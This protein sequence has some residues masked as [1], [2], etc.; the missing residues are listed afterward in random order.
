[1]KTFAVLDQVL[2]HP[3]IAVPTTLLP[4]LQRDADDPARFLPHGPREVHREESP[5]RDELRPAAERHPKRRARSAKDKVHEDDREAR[6]AHALG[7]RIVFRHRRL[8]KDAPALH[9]ERREG[10]SRKRGP[11]S[12]EGHEAGYLLADRDVLHVRLR[13]L[14]G[15]S[16]VNDAGKAGR[17]RQ[18]G[19]LNRVDTRNQIIE[20]Q[21]RVGVD[22]VFRVVH[23][24]HVEVD[25]F[26]LLVRLDRAVDVV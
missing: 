20:E 2:D 18:N 16:P 10:P 13:E 7:H 19:K 5:I 15:I 25:A 4:L 11:G 23:Q 22:D 21:K 12:G 8:V 24:E 14:V 3:R 6:F 26:P 1:M 9:L 17:K